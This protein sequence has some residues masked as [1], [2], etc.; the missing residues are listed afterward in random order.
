[1]SAIPP[2]TAQRVASL[3]TPSS[4]SSVSTPSLGV[5]RTVS[6]SRLTS[7]T[8]SSMQ[9]QSD[10]SLRSR[11]HLP[12]IAG[13]PSVG[14]NSYHASKEPKE[15]PPSALLNSVSSVPKETPTK[16]PRIS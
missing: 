1:M 12:T 10:A 11:N 6:S 5:T 3:K 4:S 9:K 15:H 13:S 7:Q 16:I 2:A 8:V 14:T